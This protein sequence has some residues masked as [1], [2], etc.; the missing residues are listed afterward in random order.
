MK[1]PGATETIQK[2]WYRLFGATTRHFQHENFLAISLLLLTSSNLQ[3]LYQGSFGTI[4]DLKYLYLS[5]LWLSRFAILRW[6]CC[7]DVS[8]NKNP[9][10]G[11]LFA[12]W[13]SSQVVAGQYFDRPNQQILA[14]Q[15]GNHHTDDVQSSVTWSSFMSPSVL[16]ALNLVKVRIWFPLLTFKERISTNGSFSGNGS[17]DSSNKREKRKMRPEG[18]TAN[19]GRLSQVLSLWRRVWGSNGQTLHFV[20]AVSTVLFYAWYFLIKSDIAETSKSTA[21]GSRDYVSMEEGVP[22]GAYRIYEKPKWSDAFFYVTSFGTL[23]SIALYGR[24]VLPFPDLVAGTNVLKAVR[25][26][27]KV[28]GVSLPKLAVTSLALRPCLTYFI[29]ETNQ[30]KTTA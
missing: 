12:H 2:I 6:L 14:K 11:G 30:D 8:T 18:G 25:N 3:A 4:G 24:L 7:S 20:L 9:T 29:A 15:I 13:M 27:A 21:G 22:Y 17:K 23:L 19:P 1:F 16:Y 10:F 26:E 5:F 28:F